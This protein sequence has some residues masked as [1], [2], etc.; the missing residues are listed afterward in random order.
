MMSDFKSK[1][2]DFKELTSMT[3]KL[4]GGIKT[5]VNE[6]IQDYKEKRAEEEAKAK[7]EEALKAKEAPVQEPVKETVVQETVV[8]V[9]EETPTTT[10]APVEPTEPPAPI[11]AEEEI[12]K[13]EDK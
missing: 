10:E 9:K 5:T 1:L 3:S 4:L 13:E 11:I 12:K 2:P 6:I 8:I 7:A